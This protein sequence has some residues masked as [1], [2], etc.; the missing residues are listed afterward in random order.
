MVHVLR[1]LV[2]RFVRYASVSA[3]ST[4]TS[5]TV[6]GILVDLAAVSAGWANVAATAVGTV[7]SF[8]LNRRWVWGKSSRRS[9][10]AEVFPF[11]ILSFTGLAISTI[12][13]HIAGSWAAARGWPATRRALLLMATN[14]AA[15]GS[16]WIL[17]FVLLDRVL[18]RPAPPAGVEPP[19]PVGA[20]V[21]SDAAPSAA[22]HSSPPGPGGRRR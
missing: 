19:A 18:F 16:L 13:V 4:A 2:P 20:G 11:T 12:T 8:E 21:V 10:A 17:Q 22:V 5:L 9:L 6:L 14:A 3:V 7:P 1:R 15:Y